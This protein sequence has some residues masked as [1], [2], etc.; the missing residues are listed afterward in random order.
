[1]NMHCPHALYAP[2]RMPSGVTTVPA[3]ELPRDGIRLTVGGG[4]L[5]PAAPSFAERAAM[6]VISRTQS[7]GDRF[8]VLPTASASAF[9]RITPTSFVFDA[10]PVDSALS[11][12]RAIDGLDV[13]HWA[14]ICEA[15]GTTM[16]EFVAS[17]WR[18]PSDTRV[19]VLSD[20]RLD[21]ADALVAQL[22]GLRLVAHCYYGSGLTYVYLLADDGRTY[23]RR[24]LTALELAL[25]GWR[26][27]PQWSDYHVTR[28]YAPGTPVREGMTTDTLFRP[29]VYCDGQWRPMDT[30][31]EVWRGNRWYPAD[32]GQS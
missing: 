31:E 7:E 14:E 5:D 20:S 17:H 15:A 2:A 1:M 22:W 19:R 26:D 23:D 13:R 18:G 12:L 16:D 3:T 25:F 9:L 24:L 27:E 32:G 10:G 4:G 8:A 11:L 21:A 28:Y 29:H 30:A 6:L